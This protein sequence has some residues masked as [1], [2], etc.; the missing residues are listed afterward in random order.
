MCETA[1]CQRG[2]AGGARLALAAVSVAE[3]R[4]VDA[5][6]IRR[7]TQ[8]WMSIPSAETR[9]LALQLTR[10]YSEGC[11][12]LLATEEG[13]GRGRDDHC[14]QIEQQCSTASR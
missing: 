10:V 5:T 6:T 8:S 3:L 12:I 7:S 14:E 1:V 13:G 9:R 4:A 11:K 2:C